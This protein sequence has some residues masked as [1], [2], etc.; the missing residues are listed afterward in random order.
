MNYRVIE[1]RDKV[2]G[3]CSG[4]KDRI[5]DPVHQRRLVLAIVCIALL[6]D[7]MLYMVIVPLIPEYLAD[8]RR[9]GE[10]MNTYNRIQHLNWTAFN[11]AYSNASL[12]YEDLTYATPMPDESQLSISV[13]FASKAI[14]QLLINPFTGMFIDRVG[15]YLPLIIGMA[16]MFM[17]TTV[18]AFGKSFAV[19]IFA[20]SLQGFGSA[21]SNAS[22]LAMLADRFPEEGERNKAFGIALAFTSF[23]SF[24]APP[25]G[26]ILYQF[27]GNIVP[28]LLLA[29]ICVI[30]GLLVLFV[31]K[32]GIKMRNVIPPED[33]PKATP[34]WRLLMDPFILVAAGA[35]TMANVP[36]AFLEPT[37]AVWM[38]KTMNSDR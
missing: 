10:E 7:D 34:I 16:I 18:F 35:L 14:F 32:P 26:G 28:F 33:R 1:L 24:F 2:S 29:S 4:L 12:W 36:L 19:L 6:L 30:D 13:L 38:D 20:R 27:V 23:G 22:G 8:L 37:I 9:N 31:M 25:F 21:F 5:N 15:Y 11:I 17:S 3:L